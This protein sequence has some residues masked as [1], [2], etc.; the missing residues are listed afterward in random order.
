M[1]GMKPGSATIGTAGTSH[2]PVLDGIRALAVLM[3]IG[4]HFWLGFGAQ[5]TLVAKIAV[6]GQTGV[7]LFLCCLAF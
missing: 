3:V 6:W 2:I 1:L 5:H 4:F 7:D